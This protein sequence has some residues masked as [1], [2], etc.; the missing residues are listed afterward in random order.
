MHQILAC[1]FGCAGVAL[2]YVGGRS[3]IAYRALSRVSRST[4]GELKPGFAY[5]KGKLA[6]KNPSA[7]DGDALYSRVDQRS[8]NRTTARD[9]RSV[10]TVIEDGTGSVEL[11]F[12]GASFAIDDSGS[13]P[14]SSIW[15]KNHPPKYTAWL[16]L[17]AGQE[18]TVIGP[19]QEVEGGLRF[20]KGAPIYVLSTRSREQLAR[21]NLKIA[22]YSALV[23]TLFLANL[24]LAILYL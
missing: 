6:P 5:V 17:Y 21:T 1:V 15:P 8:G 13:S 10:A 7:F 16:N 24:V 19:V 18:L 14:H 2:A 3:W 9:K 23:A 11:T 22:C 12:L 20:A 4:V